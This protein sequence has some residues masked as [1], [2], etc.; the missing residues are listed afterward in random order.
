[1]YTAIPL[2]HGF[3]GKSHSHG[4]FGW[5]S[6]WLLRND[7]RRVLI[8]AG[9]PA[10]ISLIHKGLAGVGLTT[11][12]ITDVVITHLHW[13]HVGNFTMYPNATTWV[14]ENELAW[15]ATLPAGTAFIPDLH[16]Q[17][18]VRRGDHIGRMHPGSEVLPGVNVIASPGHTPGHLAFSAE[19]TTGTY[20]FAGDAV[21][22]VY[23]LNTLEVDSTMDE[24]ASRRS[25]Q[26][27][28]SVLR[29]TNGLLIPGHDVPL[30]AN[31]TEFTRIQAQRAHIG[32]FADDNGEVDRSIAHA[33]FNCDESEE[34]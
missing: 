32:F 16:I 18:L 5:S 10:Y 31:G 8:D 3:P 33:E 25:I 21:K 15:A 29:D 1:M 4:A 9:P 2:V 24:A 34:A 30:H 6:I 23:E 28:K 27:L 7:E 11:A 19:T 22:N 12:D 26:R 20:I 13:D 17:E 14:G